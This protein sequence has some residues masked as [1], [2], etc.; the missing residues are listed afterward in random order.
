VD[1]L[2]AHLAHWYWQVVAASP[3]L[4][5]GGVL[6]AAQVRARR[7]PELYGAQAEREQAER[8]LDEILDA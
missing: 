5:G 3:F 1:L 7:E 4:I 8:E 6:L 2:I